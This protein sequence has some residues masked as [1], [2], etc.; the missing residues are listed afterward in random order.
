MR[1]AIAITLCAL[2]APA[3]A[4]PP[5]EGL[6][7]AAAGDWFRAAAA[8]D[9][10]EVR[11]LSAPALRVEVDAGLGCPI[12]TRGRAAAARIARKARACLFAIPAADW[13]PSEVQGDTRTV[14]FATTEETFYMFDVT[15]DARGRVL[16]VRM[17]TSHGGPPTF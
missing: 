4:D 11:R 14:Q 16:A 2:A 1:T 8:G 6:S 15:V 10:V 12:R 13:Q 9:A 3:A 5:G 17:T 7:K